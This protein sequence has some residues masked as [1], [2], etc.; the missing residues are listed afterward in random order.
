M[1]KRNTYTGSLEDL[2]GNQILLNISKLKDGTYVLKIMDE[3][4]VIKE[5]TFIKSDSGT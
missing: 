5:I 4:R 2:L 1:A 3:K